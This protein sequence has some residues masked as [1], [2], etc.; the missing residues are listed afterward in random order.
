MND[1]D[2]NAVLQTMAYTTYNGTSSKCKHNNLS[3]NTRFYKK[4]KRTQKW[5]DDITK[6]LTQKDLTAEDVLKRMKDEINK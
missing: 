4:I 6:E 2:K 3:N 1:D 5:A